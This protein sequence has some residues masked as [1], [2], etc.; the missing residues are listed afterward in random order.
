VTSVVSLKVYDLLG[1]EAATVFEGVRRPGSYETLF[2]GSRL[3]SGMYFCRL[4]ANNFV[5]TTKLILL[6]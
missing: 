2:D 3:A 5:G 6:K 1:R 4:L